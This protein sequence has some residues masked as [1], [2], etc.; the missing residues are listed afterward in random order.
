MG[1]RTDV[2]TLPAEAVRDATSVQPWVLVAK[3]GRAERRPVKL[4]L[5]STGRVEVAA[6]LKEGEIVLP[7]ASGVEPGDKVRARS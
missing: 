2:L 4:G 3:D 6:G 7:P 5:R 1:E